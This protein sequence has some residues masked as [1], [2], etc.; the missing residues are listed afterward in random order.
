MYGKAHEKCKKKVSFNNHQQLMDYLRIKEKLDVVEKQ[1]GVK[2]NKE[3]P[4]DLIE[5]FNST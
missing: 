4:H 5:T 3:V 2:L 1:L